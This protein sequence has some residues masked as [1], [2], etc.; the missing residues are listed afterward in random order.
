MKK[1]IL[2]IVV[3]LVAVIGIS[4]FIYLKLFTARIKYNFGISSMSFASLNLIDLLTKGASEFT[5]GVLTEIENN[6]GLSVTIA[7]PFVRLYYN[8][9]L[10]AYSSNDTQKQSVAITKMG[11]VSFNEDLNIIVGSNLI[12]LITNLRNNSDVKLKYKVNFKIFG[13]PMSTSDYY[14]I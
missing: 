5:I 8:E 14:K 6:N 1:D 10:I 2:I 11:K 12:D 3:V 4:A 7:D 9:K 13:I